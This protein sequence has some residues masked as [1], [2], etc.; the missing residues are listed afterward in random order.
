MSTKQIIFLGYTKANLPEEIENRIKEFFNENYP[1]K[2]GEIEEYIREHNILEI[3][4]VLKKAAYERKVEDWERKVVAADIYNK[5]LVLQKNVNKFLNFKNKRAQ[6]RKML[7]VYAS[8]N[9]LDLQYD[10]IL[11]TIPS[12]SQAIIDSEPDYS[13]P[14]KLK[15]IIQVDSEEKYLELREEILKIMTVKEQAT[16]IYCNFME[17]WNKF[18]HSP[19]YNKFWTYG[20]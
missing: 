3:K 15:T 2:E 6:M 18:E 7:D 16:S 10:E 20:S 19:D 8:I 4:N 11:K 13:K 5:F 17:L 9:N 12:K 14:G 1:E